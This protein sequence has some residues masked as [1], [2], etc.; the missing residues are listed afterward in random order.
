MTGRPS[1]QRPRHF[2][3]RTTRQSRLRALHPRLERPD[4]E[5]PSLHISGYIEFSGRRK[6]SIGRLHGERAGIERFGALAGCGGAILVAREGRLALRG[7]IE[8]HG[9][10][11]GI[12]ISKVE[13]KGAMLDVK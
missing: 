6:C 12:E 9:G 1:S 10:H 13:K 4:L 7:W 3:K 8:G 11:G 5:F 2:L